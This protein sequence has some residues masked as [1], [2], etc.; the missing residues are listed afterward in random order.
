MEVEEKG[1]KNLNYTAA[2]NFNKKQAEK[3]RRRHKMKNKIKKIK[4][5]NLFNSIFKYESQKVKCYNCNLKYKNESRKIIK[6]NKICFLVGCRRCNNRVIAGECTSKN[7]QKRLNRL[8]TGLA[9]IIFTR[10]LLEVS[11]TRQVS[12]QYSM[13]VWIV[14][15]QLNRL[16]IV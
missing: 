7:K 2:D 3:N 10:N 12:Y 9:N 16:A 1:D 13:K 15:L 11:D 8:R 14:R 4:I 5:E 6:N